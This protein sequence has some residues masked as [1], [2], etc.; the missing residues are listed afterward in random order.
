MWYKLIRDTVSS[1]HL[2]AEKNMIYNLF[3]G[4]SSEMLNYK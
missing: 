4:E 1:P 3:V 2:L